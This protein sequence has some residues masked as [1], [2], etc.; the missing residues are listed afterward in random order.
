MS[1]YAVRF[2]Y[3]LYVVR[4][5]SEDEARRVAY[6]GPAIDSEPA[7]D[8]GVEWDPEAHVE[9]LHDAGPATLLAFHYG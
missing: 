3:G 1:L 2:G 8:Y 5:S 4:A 9:A 6:E 7:K